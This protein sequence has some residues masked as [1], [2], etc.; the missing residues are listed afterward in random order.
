MAN[1]QTLKAVFLIYLTLSANPL[2]QAQQAKPL[3]SS[4]KKERQLK[5]TGWKWCS[6]FTTHKTKHYYFDV[7]YSDK[8]CE[9]GA[10][11]AIEL[12]R[13]KERPVLNVFEHRQWTV[14]KGDDGDLEFSLFYPGPDYSDRSI[15]PHQDRIIELTKVDV[16]RFYEAGKDKDGN[17]LP[18]KLEIIMPQTEVSGGYR[19]SVAFEIEG[20]LWYNPEILEKGMEKVVSNFTKMQEDASRPSY[21]VTG[22][23]KGKWIGGI[24]G[25]LTTAGFYTAATLSGV[26]VQTQALIGASVVGLLGGA[27]LGFA[28]GGLLGVAITAVM[29]MAGYKIVRG[30]KIVS[31]SH[32]IFEKLRC[33][34]EFEQCDKY[35]LVPKGK[36]CPRSL[37][38]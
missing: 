38:V 7:E 2:A 16:V 3:L 4:A 32:K 29:V 24:G 35:T 10:C 25:V 18:E 6:P 19:T 22:Q 1:F 37:F 17:V 28:L 11:A 15:Y 23:N 34:D 33:L 14:K 30:M 5:S 26:A 13:H 21:R 27:A 20:G 12:V 9:D 36:Q 8:Q 31:A